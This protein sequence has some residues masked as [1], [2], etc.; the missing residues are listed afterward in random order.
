MRIVG[1]RRESGTHV[2]VSATERV[3]VASVPPCSAA[4]YLS[5][6]TVSVEKSYGLPSSRILVLNF[7]QVRAREPACRNSERPFGCRHLYTVLSR[8]KPSE[9][10]LGNSHLKQTK[11]RSDHE[12]VPY[13][14]GTDL[15]SRR[16][17][18]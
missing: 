11:Q 9:V 18:A 12:N 15:Q 16:A 5:H 8:K 14:Y 10:H 3:T 17:R 13:P 7:R 4:R 6:I 1:E 2:F